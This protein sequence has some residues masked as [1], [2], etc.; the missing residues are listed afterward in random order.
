M[1]CTMPPAAAVAN[2]NSLFRGK[3]NETAPILP[4]HNTL[5]PA[6]A[7]SES[8]PRA[9]NPWEQLY[10]LV[11][12]E[13]KTIETVGGNVVQTSNIVYSNSIQNAWG[14]LKKR[15]CRFLEF[16]M[17]DRGNEARNETKI[18]TSQ[19][20]CKFTKSEIFGLN[21]ITD[22]PKH[23]EIGTIYFCCH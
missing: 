10:Q 18:A 8:P 22:Y 16:P 11:N 21:I 20:H 6:Y 2:L 7:R 4:F 1:S 5:D 13:A 12:E 23:A 3:D 9:S 19:N 15:K 14:S 17:A